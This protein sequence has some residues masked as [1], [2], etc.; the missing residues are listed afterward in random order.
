MSSNPE[1]EIAIIKETIS[2]VEVAESKQAWMEQ[3]RQWRIEYGDNGHVTKHSSFPL[4]L[5]GAP[6]GSSEC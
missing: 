1:D 3:V 6:P 2:Q 4:Q 5:G